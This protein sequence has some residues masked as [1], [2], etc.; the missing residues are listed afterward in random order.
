MFVYTCLFALFFSIDIQNIGC[1][2]VQN[3]VE[4]G[5]RTAENLA[6]SSML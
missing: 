2:L 3:T 6:F 4:N 1:I 5:E